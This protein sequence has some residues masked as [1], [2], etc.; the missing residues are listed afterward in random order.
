MH[1][2]GLQPGHGNESTEILNY[3]YAYSHK[4]CIF[5]HFMLICATANT[6]HGSFLVTYQATRHWRGVNSDRAA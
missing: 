1:V 3:N 5:T 4:L 2:G 6:M